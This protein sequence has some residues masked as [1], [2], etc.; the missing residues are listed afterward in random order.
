[1]ISYPYLKSVIGLNKAAMKLP[2][3]VSQEEI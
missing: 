3:K 1:M 2:C